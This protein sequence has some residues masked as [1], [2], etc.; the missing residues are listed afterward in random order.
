[1]YDTSPTTVHRNFSF[2]QLKHR[3]VPH[4][5]ESAKKDENNDEKNQGF[6]FIDQVDS[7]LVYIPAD[8]IDQQRTRHAEPCE[9]GQIDEDGV[10]INQIQLVSTTPVTPNLLPPSQSSLIPSILPVTNSK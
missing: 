1:M 4:R 10:D 5:Y 3:L 7:D 8:N 9:H 6:L 2:S